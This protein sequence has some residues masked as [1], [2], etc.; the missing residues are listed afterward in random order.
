MPQGCR[1][2]G[3]GKNMDYTLNVC[4]PSKKTDIY[5]LRELKLSN[6]K[7]NITVMKL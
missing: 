7:F 2:R 4:T 3:M 6:S 1:I 5:N